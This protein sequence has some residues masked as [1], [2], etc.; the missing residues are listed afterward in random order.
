MEEVMMQRWI[1]IFGS[2]LLAFPLA[3]NAQQYKVSGS[4][5]IEGDGGWDYLLADSANGSSMY[6]TAPRSTSWTWL[7]RSRWQR[8]PE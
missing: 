6:L 3:A 7:R 8:S 1:V 2:L 4:I 5:P